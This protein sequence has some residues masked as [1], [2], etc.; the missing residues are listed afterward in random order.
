MSLDAF[1][2]TL[3]EVR[4]TNVTKTVHRE[5]YGAI[6]PTRSELNQIGK[7]VLITG[8]GTGV[9]LA[10]AKAFV[11]ASASIVIII[12]RRADVLETAREALQYEAKARG[13]STKIIV[14]TCDISKTADVDAMWDHFQEEKMAIDVFIAN[15]AAFQE[16]ETMMSLGTDKIWKMMEVNVKASMELAEKF[17][18]QPGEK[19]K[20][21]TIFICPSCRGATQISTDLEET[22]HCKCHHWQHS[23]HPPPRCIYLPGIYAIKNGGDVVL[24]V[25]GAGTCA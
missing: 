2:N 11:Q 16:A 6:S 7:N 14:K 24:P 21:R 15:A 5:P 20:V 13:T 12:G 17:V 22:V 8:G 19:Q 25:Y 1:K 23:R 4:Q 18:N 3:K 10:I 9:G